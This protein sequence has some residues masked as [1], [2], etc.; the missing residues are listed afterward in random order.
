M[1]GRKKIYDF[2]LAGPMRHY[3]ALNQPMFT[4]VAGLLRERGFTVWSPSEHDDYRTLSLAQCM[5]ADL[6]AVINQCHKIA[7]LPDWR[8]SFGANV[9]AFTAFACGKG[10]MEIILNSSET[11]WGLG[12]PTYIELISFDLSKYHLPYQNGEIHQFNPHKCSF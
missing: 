4:L 12:W 8:E 2:Y 10:A 9:E 11:K 1:F 5:T 7:L 3:P 6:N